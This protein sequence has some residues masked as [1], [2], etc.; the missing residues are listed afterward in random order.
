MLLAALVVAGCEDSPAP[1]TS[2]DPGQ[3]KRV[4]AGA[5]V[6]MKSL[7]SVGLAISTEGEPPISI[8]GGDIKLRKNGDATGRLRI[9]QSG[10]TVETEFVLLGGTAY[11]KGA[12]GGYQR[13]PAGMVAAVYDPSAVLDPNRGISKLLTSATAP[14]LAGE[15]KVDGTR[16]YRVKLTL[17]RESAATLIPGISQDLPGQVWIAVDGDRLLKVKADVPAVE[18]GGKGSVT[19][20][21][22][23][24]DE[25]Y[26]IT[27]PK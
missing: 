21:F 16:A 8:A 1:T 26:E 27:A 3:G 11:L 20:A 10:Q 9:R 2:A 18:G 5:A 4:L 17:P 24:F 12:T 23:E 14:R 19:V 7:K 6:A 15:E 13:L 25:T 22:T